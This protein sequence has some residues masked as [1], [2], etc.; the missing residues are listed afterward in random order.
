MILMNF[1]RR[2]GLTQ[3]GL[4]LGVLDS[5][6]PDL[7]DDLVHGLVV[8][9]FVGRVRAIERLA[10]QCLQFG[11]LLV[12]ARPQ[13]L[14]ESLSFASTFSFLSSLPAPSFTAV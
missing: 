8:R 12:G 7:A 14:A 5:G 3:E 6:Q 13:A 10:V 4:E 11:F 1:E 9:Q 2:Q